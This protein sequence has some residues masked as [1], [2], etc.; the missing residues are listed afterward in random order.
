VRAAVERD[1]ELAGS[2]SGALSRAW[3][4]HMKTADAEKAGGADAADT[5]MQVTKSDDEA[6]GSGLACGEET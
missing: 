2:C 3:H 4:G 5:S 6:D 1:L